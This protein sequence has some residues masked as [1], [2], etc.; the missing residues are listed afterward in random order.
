MSDWNEYEIRLVF[1]NYFIQGVAY[2]ETKEDAFFAFEGSLDF[3]IPEPLE[4]EI[5][6]TAILQGGY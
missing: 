4:T 5:T 3:A 2:G 1:T 6:H